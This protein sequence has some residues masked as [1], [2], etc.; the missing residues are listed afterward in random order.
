MTAG[1]L[2]LVSKG[3][4]DVYFVGQ[5]GVFYYS[6]VYRYVPETAWTQSVVQSK[7]PAKW[8]SQIEF[9]L[10]AVPD[11]TKNFFL[12]IH[13][14]SWLPTAVPAA[15]APTDA[16]GNQYGYVNCP[17]LYLFE[18]IEVLADTHI[19]QRL[20]PEWLDLAGRRGLLGMADGT[21]Q[22]AAEFGRMVGR[23]RATT[24]PDPRPSYTY[25][26]TGE[27]ELLR[28][29]IVPLPI[30]GCVRPTDPPFPMRAVTGSRI[31]IRARLKKIDSLIES[32]PV[33]GLLPFNKELFIDDESVGI[34]QEREAFSRG[35][36]VSITYTAGYV[37]PVVRD[38]IALRPHAVLIEHVQDQE[39]AIERAVLL[40]AAAGSP[41]VKPMRIDFRGPVKVITVAFQ[42]SAARLARTPA[43]YTNSSGSASQI[44][45]ASSLRL[46]TNGRDRFP[47]WAPFFYADPVHY[48]APGVSAAQVDCVFDFG[49]DS[50]GRSP[51]GTLNFSAA[52]KILLSVQLGTDIPADSDRIFVNVFGV[53]YK[54]LVVKNGFIEV[55]AVPGKDIVC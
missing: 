51:T 38:M 28:T 52:D 29:L 19:I 1:L 42:R 31:T 13:L 23:R 10:D 53:G 14:P 49:L 50:G 46:I 45:V 9:E 18:H 44:S 43:D 7:S 3:K 47:S 20:T 6:N 54:V 25:V 30:L 4:K 2:E 22:A 24:T 16:S 33:R 39:F 36:D 34:I 21:I 15:A 41:D 26:S 40:A 32:Y 48:G 55:G 35:P 17:A 8:G 37:S 27:D 5:P 11:L 12:Q